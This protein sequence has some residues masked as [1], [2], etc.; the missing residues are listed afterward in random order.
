MVEKNS[1][2]LQ[3]MELSW[4]AVLAWIG[5][6]WVLGALVTS[7]FETW[8]VQQTSERYHV[9]DDLR[10]L[11]RCSWCE[12]SFEALQCRSRGEPRLPKNPATRSGRFRMVE[13][14]NLPFLHHRRYNQPHW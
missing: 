7:H 6:L 2:Y 13:K 5:P 8:M 3:H 10:D 1:S 14:P 9:G 11:A 12:R 4:V